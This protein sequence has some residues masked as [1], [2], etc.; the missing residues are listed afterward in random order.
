[1]RTMSP[2]LCTWMRAPSIFHS[3]AASPPSWRSASAGSAAVCASI[4]A[5][6]D[7]TSS[8]NRARPASPSSSAARATAPTF[9]AY[10][11]AR[12][13]GTGVS[14]AAAAIASIMTPASA[15][16]R[17]SPAIRR[18]TNS[19]SDS[20]ARANNAR[21]ASVAAGRRAGATQCGDLAE[22]AIDV[23]DRQR[24]PCRGFAI[25]GV[26]ERRIADAEPALR[27]AAGEVL[28]ADRDLVRIERA[29]PLGQRTHFREPRRRRGDGFGGIDEIG[30]QRH[31]VSIG[32]RRARDRQATIVPPGA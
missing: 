27:R 24:R 9:F 29:Q 12:R 25:A 10:I 32:D 17:S 8:W 2:D 6:G 23:G 13:T 30:Q 14:L 26:V 31:R 11:I 15:P 22:R 18:I 21:S 3:N 19:R 16:W 5:I 7:S 4:G 20:V 1:M 28:R